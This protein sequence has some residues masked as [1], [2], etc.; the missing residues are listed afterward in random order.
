[1]YDQSFSNK[2]RKKNQSRVL[3]KHDTSPICSN[4]LFLIVL[5]AEYNYQTETFV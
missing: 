5:N 2:Q 4:T 3:L 1:M